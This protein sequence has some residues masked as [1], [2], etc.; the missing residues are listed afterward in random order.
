[1]SFPSLPKNRAVLTASRAGALAAL[2]A[3]TTL[4][5]CMSDRRIVENPVDFDYRKNHPIV[6]SRGDRTI[7]IFVAGG[8]GAIGARQIS[9]IRSSPRS[10]SVGRA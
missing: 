2:T 5:A 7:D 9:D 3:L 10:T 8:P 4:T 6:L 1:M